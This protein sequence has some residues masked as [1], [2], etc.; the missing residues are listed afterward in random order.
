MSI[1]CFRFYHFIKFRLSSTTWF[2]LAANLGLRHRQ[3]FHNVGRSCQQVWI[4]VEWLGIVLAVSLGG[5]QLS[6]CWYIFHWDISWPR[7]KLSGFLLEGRD[8]GYKSDYWS[9]E[10]QVGKETGGFTILYYLYHS[11]IFSS[12]PLPSPQVCSVSCLEMLSGST[13][14]DK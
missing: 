12:V 1:Y 7:E 2:S 6:V 10:H 5:S 13:F 3:N 11:S 8:Y 14:S 4:T 9:S